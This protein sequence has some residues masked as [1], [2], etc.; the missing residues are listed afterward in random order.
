MPNCPL[1]YRK[2]ITTLKQNELWQQLDG[3]CSRH[4]P[5]TYREILV[6]TWSRCLSPILHMSYEVHQKE[7]L[8]CSVCNEEL[9]NIYQPSN[10]KVL[11]VI[12]MSWVWTKEGRFVSVSLTFCFTFLLLMKSF[13]PFFSQFDLCVHTMWLQAAVSVFCLCP[14]TLIC[15][16]LESLW[17]SDEAAWINNWWTEVCWGEEGQDRRLFSIFI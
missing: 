13:P 17:P 10:I 8:Y 14:G 12:M 9:Q 4:K 1:F 5:S 2:H 6:Y 11:F 16:T 15:G 7:T 3:T